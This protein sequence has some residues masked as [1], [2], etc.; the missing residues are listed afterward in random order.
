MSVVFANNNALGEVDLRLTKSVQPTNQALGGIVTY[1]IKVTNDDTTTTAM[2]VVAIDELPNGPATGIV[3]IT[4]GSF[5]LTS[6]VWDGFDL[7][8]L[9]SLNY[10]LL[11]QFL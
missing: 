10:D 3:E 2:T 5:D 11:P 7:L 1:T 4:H 6:G 8:H 9:K